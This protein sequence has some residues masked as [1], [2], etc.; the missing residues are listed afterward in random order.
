[1]NHEHTDIAIVG[2][3]LMG[4]SAA[5]LL[6]QVLPQYSITL[7]EKRSF[8][9]KSEADQTLPS[10]DARSTAL[11]PTSIHLMQRLGVWP[12]ITAHATAIR[13]IQVSDKGHAGW[14]RLTEADN[15]NNPLGAV[16]ENHALGRAL[17]AAVGAAPAVHVRAPA[18][19]TA[20]L[21]KSD[22]AELT[23]AGGDTLQARLV[24]V[25]DGAGSPVAQQLGISVD[26]EDYQQHA[27]I[28]NVAYD[29]PHQGVAYER[30]TKQGP[31]AL[32]PLGGSHSH[33]SA[34]VWTWPSAHISEAMAMPEAEF[35]YTLQRQFGHR[36]GR[37]RAVSKRSH[38]P[39]CLS[40]AREQVRSRVVL[41]GNAAHFLHPVAGQ[42]YN[43]ALRDILRL[44][45][46]LRA[47][48]PALLGELPSLQRYQQLQRDDQM[49]TIRLSDG[50][51][52]AFG[53]S[54]IGL[55]GLRNLGMMAVESSSWVRNGFIRQMSGRASAQAN[56]WRNA[57]YDA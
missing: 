56:P 53:S 39:L 33:T 41:L 50:F 20:I 10:F 31:M 44:T 21:P 38:Y 49:R 3:G 37:F 35:L 34:L 24:I 55:T 36:L 51:N 18:T 52:R 14:V 54:H 11:A 25:A 32:L 22:S 28:A 27:V 15:D 19:V 46:V 4:T 13:A 9:P 26:V 8:T 7:L 45:E 43:L 23:L 40:V 47:L 30:F 2:G 16:V 29:K 6:A 12:A 57:E 5:L 17:I 1:M 42:G 48:P